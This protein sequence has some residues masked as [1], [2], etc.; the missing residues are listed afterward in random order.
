MLLSIAVVFVCVLLGFGM[1]GILGAI[2]GYFIA[3]G[4]VKL[5]KL[6]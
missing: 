6:S 3:C 4:I 5:A 1:G 2:V